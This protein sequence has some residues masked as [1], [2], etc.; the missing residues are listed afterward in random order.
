MPSNKDSNKAR[1][2]LQKDLSTGARQSGDTRGIV[3]GRRTDKTLEGNVAIVPSQFKRYNATELYQRFL[4]NSVDHKGNYSCGFGQ[5]GRSLSVAA[6]YDFGDLIL[7]GVVSAPVGA[8][9]KGGLGKEVLFMIHRSAPNT[10]YTLSANGQ[11]NAIWKTPKSVCFTVLSGKAYALSAKVDASIEA[12]TGF[13]TSIGN[14]DS[15]QPETTALGL[16]VELKAAL[17]AKAGLAG[18]VYRLSADQIGFYADGTGDDIVA[19]FAD[20]IGGPSNKSLEAEIV[21]WCTYIFEYVNAQQAQTVDQLLNELNKQL[22]ITDKIKELVKEKVME[23][24]LGKI[25]DANLKSLAQQ[26]IEFLHGKFTFNNQNVLHLLNEVDTFYKTK[27]IAQNSTPAQPAT[28]SWVRTAPQ[29][30]LVEYKALQ[31]QI[32]WYKQQINKNTGSNTGT[33]AG[34]KPLEQLLCYADLYSFAANAQIGGSASGKGGGSTGNG[35]VSGGGSGSAT[36]GGDAKFSSSRYQSCVPSK[37]PVLPR[38]VFTQDTMTTYRR[39]QGK[40]TWSATAG[41]NFMDYGIEKGKEGEISKLFFDLI[42]YESIT[43]YWSHPKT[44]EAAT[45]SLR[46][47]S[48]VSFGCS[49]NFGRL[50]N[51]ALSASPTQADQ[52]LLQDIARALHVRVQNLNDFLTKAFAPSPNAQVAA[53]DPL[54]ILNN[55]RTIILEAN[56]AFTQST[57]LNLKKDSKKNVYNIEDLSKAAAVK[58]IIS[59]ISQDVKSPTPPA[60]PPAEYRLDSI[61]LRVRNEDNLGN[62]DNSKPIF[63]LGFDF[64]A[65]IKLTYAKTEKASGNEGIWDVYT[66]W[67]NPAYETKPRDGFER[68]VPPTILLPHSLFE[69]SNTEPIS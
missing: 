50:Q 3:I 5:Y 67:M 33:S 4:I 13:T 19:A 16:D 52:K 21:E 38:L 20:A 26:L 58:S 32:E 9:V 18:E 42:T 14:T 30:V 29:K 55:Y 54:S 46:L 45:A 40:A 39:I 49:I 34:P 47:G 68:S 41:V 56:Y 57:T 66:G 25:Q 7:P 23:T 64:R 11:V 1:E 17:S 37:S 61:R 44:N 36:V 60:T 51:I 63:E 69:K 6:S 43:A 12:G 15:S 48:G 35:G 2:A 53:D 31:K 28:Q 22:S 62:Y 10:L 59:K 8:E 65:A 24:I 27:L